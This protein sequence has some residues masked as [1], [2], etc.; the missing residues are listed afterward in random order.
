M[1][2]TYFYS[3]LLCCCCGSIFG[4]NGLPMVAGARGAGMGN[5]S[6]GFQDVHSL[7][8]NQ[9]GLAHLDQVAFTAIGESR[10]IDFGIRSLAAGMG[11]P[12]NAG[13]FGLA[14]QYFGIQEYNEQKVGLAYGRKLFDQLSIG[15]QMDY[16]RLQIPDYGSRNLFTF[17]LGLQSQVSKRLLLGFHTFSPVQV[18][19]IAEEFLPSVFRLGA[20]YKVSSKLNIAAE[21]EKDINFPVEVHVGLEYALIEALL[22][23]V[24]VQTEPSELSLGLGYRLQ[25]KLLIDVAAS[26]HQFLGVSPTFNVSY[27]LNKKT[28][29]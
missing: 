16:L 9:A 12:T 28:K 27:L 8:G 13:T 11:Y 17:E 4:Q 23:R 2:K 3:L 1:N 26:Y 14:V 21:L 10:Y 7:F 20:A 6:I 22:L 18:E 29:N 19:I 15:V 25:D 24:G 5:A